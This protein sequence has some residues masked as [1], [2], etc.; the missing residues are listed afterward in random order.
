MQLENWADVIVAASN[1]AGLIALA[2]L[3]VG[4]L[5][6]PMTKGVS[7]KI[8]TV[9]FIFLVICFVS[10]LGLYLA[11][12]SG[13]NTQETPTIDMD[14]E[15]VGGA[16]ENSPPISNPAYAAGEVDANITGN[17][18]S[19]E[20]ANYQTV[21]L[22]VN[23]P[24]ATGNIIPIEGKFELEV[25]NITAPQCSISIKST[26]TGLV[27]DGNIFSNAGV[28]EFENYIIRFTKI[29]TPFINKSCYFDIQ[30]KEIPQG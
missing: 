15:S 11:N 9:V 20:T 18:N 27:V 21:I 7:P 16:T 24:V 3:V 6:V 26:A 2:L 4:S 29:A 12:G 5:A 22:S 23:Q 25:T 17:V 14:T 28:W 8:R 19:A 10:S 1:N 13:D 30:K